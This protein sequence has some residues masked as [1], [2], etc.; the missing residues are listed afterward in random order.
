MNSVICNNYKSG[1]K[2][3]DCVAYLFSVIY[4]YQQLCEENRKEVY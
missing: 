1:L 3:C 4:S 2:L